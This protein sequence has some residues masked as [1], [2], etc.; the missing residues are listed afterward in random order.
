MA[1]M[2][3]SAQRTGTGG[4]RPV[5]LAVLTP[6]DHGA[7]VLRYAALVAAVDDCELRVLVLRPRLGFTTDAALV[8]ARRGVRR[9]V[10]AIVGDLD[11]DLTVE[12]LV[13]SRRTWRDQ[14]LLWSDLIRA[15]RDREARALVVPPGLGQG[16]PR[17]VPGITVI[18]VLRPAGPDTSSAGAAGGR[19]S[20]GDR[21]VGSGPGRAAP[22]RS[23]LPPLGRWWV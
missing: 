17:E 8:A 11:A 3:R 1:T 12:E 19:V 14:G 13:V 15:G 18:S 2:T 16:A 20:G 22:G 9:Q 23:A 10:L 5:V 6:P 4:K 7:L 21:P